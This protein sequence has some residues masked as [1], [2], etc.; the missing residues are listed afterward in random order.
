MYQFMLE[1]NECHALLDYIIKMLRTIY[2]DYLLQKESNC[3]LFS[4]SKYRKHFELSLC[5]LEE[6]VKKSFIKNKCIC[7]CA[8]ILELLAHL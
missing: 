4:A 7:G 5:N 6:N 3:Y 8:I 2:Y 1:M